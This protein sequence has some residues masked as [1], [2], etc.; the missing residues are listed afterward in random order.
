MIRNYFNHYIPF[1]DNT[2]KE[3]V[4]IEK[5][6]YLF[7][8]S[9]FLLAACVPGTMPPCFAPPPPPIED[10]PHHTTAPPG[11]QRS[12]G[13]SNRGNYSD[14]ETCLCRG[15]YAD[16]STALLHGYSPN[17]GHYSDGEQY[18]QLRHC[19]CS[20]DE[21]DFEPHYLEQTPSGNVFIP[22]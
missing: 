6:D 11:R 12:F 17:R 21:S 8:L 7:T 2:R 16:A 3:T 5:M 13:P 1:S 18:P 4:K 15:H 9:H 20:G 19:P 10:I 22:G 14:A